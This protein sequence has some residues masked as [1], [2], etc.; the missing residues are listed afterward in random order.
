MERPSRL[1]SR[2][3]ETAIAG[4]WASANGRAR[5]GRGERAR[6]MV[7]AS[8]PM[9]KAATPH[10]KRLHCYVGEEMVTA[11]ADAGGRRQ[12]H[13]PGGNEARYYREF[14]PRFRPAKY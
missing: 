5:A 3:P 1:T 8:L 13:S 4:A 10:H 7:N 2:P 12:L 11:A 14:A 6:P 9:V